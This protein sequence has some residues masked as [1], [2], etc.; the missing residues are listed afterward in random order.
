MW[1]KRSLP[2]AQQPDSRPFPESAEP[3]LRCLILFLKIYQYYPP[4]YVRL[5][6]LFLSLRFIHRNILRLFLLLR[7]CRMIRMTRHITILQTETYFNR[8]FAL[9][10]KGEKTANTYDTKCVINC[11]TCRHF[12]SYISDSDFQICVTHIKTNFGFYFGHSKRQWFYAE[13]QKD[14]NG[15]Y[16]GRVYHCQSSMKREKWIW[17]EIPTWCNNLFITINNATCFGHLYAQL[18]SIMLYTYY[19]TPYGVQHCKSELCVSGL[20]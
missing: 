17:R 11:A 20:L 9:Y 12:S 8:F 18:Q 2:Y 5:S 3:C 13:V 6:K 15:S 7:M 14:S 10:D 19:A 4:I 1:P 16:S